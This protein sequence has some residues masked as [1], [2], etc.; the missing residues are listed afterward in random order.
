MGEYLNNVGYKMPYPYWSPD[1][2]NV[3]QKHKF[4]ICFENTKMETYSTEK[5]VNPFLSGTIPIYWGSN[6]VKNIFN[7]DTILFLKDESE[8]SINKLIEQIIELD[9]NDTKYLE[10]INRPIFTEENIKFWNEHYT[11]DSLATKFNEIIN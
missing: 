10:F 7:T 8:E 3:L 1:Y 11:I 4:M 9:N 6:N 2:F 5:I